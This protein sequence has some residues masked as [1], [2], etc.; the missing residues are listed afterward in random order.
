MILFYFCSRKATNTK[1][2][3][4]RD[5]LKRL[6]VC[7]VIFWNGRRWMS[8]LLFIPAKCYFMESSLW[9]IYFRRN[10]NI[11]HLEIFLLLFPFSSGFFCNERQI[12]MNEAIISN[13]LVFILLTG[14]VEHQ[15][16]FIM[17]IT[18]CL[19]I[20]FVMNINLNIAGEVLFIENDFTFMSFLKRLLASRRRS[21][22]LLA[23]VLIEAISKLSNFIASCR[24][25][26]K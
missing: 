2:I 1:L 20:I 16:V 18:I 19:Y 4:I 6:V 22:D 25:H 3:W 23:R 7:K 24:F 15:I 12:F 9:R 8:I 5:N 13:R 14:R 10:I 21:K 11:V 17:R 26:L